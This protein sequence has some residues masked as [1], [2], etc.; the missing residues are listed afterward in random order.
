MNTQNQSAQN[1]GQATDQNET[2]SQATEKQKI[3]ASKNSSALYR[4]WE[5]A[6]DN[7]TPTELE[8]FS[9]LTDVAK[10]ELDS[11]SV[12]TMTIGCL[13]YNV[14]RLHEPGAENIGEIFWSLSSQLDHI[15]GL[16]EVSSNAAYRLANP[17]TEVNGKV[18]A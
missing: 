15:T 10:A 12:N 9:D 5:V 16:L 8:W 6:V 18:G 1:S 4:L 17:K 11:L 13:L 7:L 14:E 3:G 2:H